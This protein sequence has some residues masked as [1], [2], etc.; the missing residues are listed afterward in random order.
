MI[1]EDFFDIGVAALI[2]FA[3]FS[4]VFYFIYLAVAK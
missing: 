4:L 1:K 3:S 2:S